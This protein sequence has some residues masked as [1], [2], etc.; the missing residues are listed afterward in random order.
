MTLG[1]RIRLYREEKGLS[2]E[3]FADKIHVS[4]QAI[5]KWENDKGLPDIANLIEISNELNVTVDELIKGEQSVKESAV[6]ER[7]GNIKL[8]FICAIT[9]FMLTALWIMIGCVNLQSDYTIVPVSNFICAS[10]TLAT[11]IVHTIKYAKL[12]EQ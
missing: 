11:A 5:T 2:Q 7:Q 1:E 4:R 6:K 10:I 3:Q 9:F 12:R 8:S